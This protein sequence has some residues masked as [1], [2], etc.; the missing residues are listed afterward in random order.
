MSLSRNGKSR[1]N[2][3]V[4]STRLGKKV[5][6]DKNAHPTP[7]PLISFFGKM[8]KLL[9]LW[10]KQNEQQTIISYQQK[11]EENKMNYKQLVI[12]CK[13]LPATLSGAT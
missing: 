7:L 12:I 11:V 9:V 6:C 5:A 10:Q 2:I 1:D 3:L 8:G 4:L 13:K